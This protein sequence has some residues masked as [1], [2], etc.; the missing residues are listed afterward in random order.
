VV[1]SGLTS[2][3]GLTDTGKVVLNRNPL[4]DNLAP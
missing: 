4:H 2:A 3:L 1:V